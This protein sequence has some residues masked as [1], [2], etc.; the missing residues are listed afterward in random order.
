MEL[1]IICIAIGIGLVVSLLIYRSSKKKAKE[2]ELLVPFRVFWNDQIE[3]LLNNH[4]PLAVIKQLQLKREKILAIAKELDVPEGHT[5]FILIIPKKYWDKEYPKRTGVD[6]NNIE[7]IVDTPSEPYAIFDIE[8]GSKHRGY[9]PREAQK[10]LE[11]E[12]R[13]PLTAEE[14]IMFAQYVP[15]LKDHH[16]NCTGSRCRGD[17]PGVYLSGGE[18]PRLNWRSLEFG[19]VGWGSPSCRSRH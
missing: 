17:V 3:I 12:G 1:S 9:S 16:L 7:N 19:G 18:M 5:P 2:E 14:C 8:D 11:E 6:V 4:F 13:S 10:I 15:V